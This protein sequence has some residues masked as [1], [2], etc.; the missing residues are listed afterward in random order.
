MYLQRFCF[1]FSLIRPE[2]KKIKGKPFVPVRAVPVDLFPDT[3]HCELIILFERYSD[4]LLN[5]TVTSDKLLNETVT[6]DKLLNDTVTSDK[7]LN[8]TVK[9]C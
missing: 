5:E 2:S 3:M 8:D 1:H 6:S 4:K 7:L 9:S